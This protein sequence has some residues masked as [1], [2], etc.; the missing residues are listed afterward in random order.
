MS[1]LPTEDSREA[2]QRYDLTR[3]YDPGPEPGEGGASHIAPADEAK[4]R[5]T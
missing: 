2:L 5:W 1:K 4:R 3:S